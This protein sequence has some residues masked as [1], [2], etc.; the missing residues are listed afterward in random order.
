MRWT[1]AGFSGTCSKLSDLA[2]ATFVL[3]RLFQSVQRWTAHPKCPYVT[4]AL[5]VYR[6]YVNAA[7]PADG[8]A[9][10]IQT[11]WFIMPARNNQCGW[12]HLRMLDA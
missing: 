2:V 7:I 10:I 5:R 4:N 11:E 9:G 6:V 12:R 3:S 1:V 8:R